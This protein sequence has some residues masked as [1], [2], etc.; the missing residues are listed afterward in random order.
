MEENFNSVPHTRSRILEYRYGAL[1]QLDTNAYNHVV[2]SVKLSDGSVYVLDLAGAQ[3]GQIDAVM[4]EEAYRKR[5]HGSEWSADLRGEKSGYFFERFT[6]TVKG[7]AGPK[8]PNVNSAA[9][10]Q[11]LKM[12]YDLAQR[13]LM[14]TLQWEAESDKTL[15]QLLG[16]RRTLFRESTNDLLNSINID[17]TDELNGMETQSAAAS[18]AWNI[19]VSS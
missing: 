7:T 17:M 6:N 16:D 19:I 9:Q 8:L 2:I 18:G 13:M 5:Y 10:L 15:Q 14:S 11:I 3:Y 1:E 4:T 12:Q